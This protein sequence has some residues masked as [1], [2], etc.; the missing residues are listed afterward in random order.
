MHVAAFWLIYNNQVFLG[1]LVLGIV[2]GRCG[3]LMHEGGHYSLTGYIPIDRALQVVLYGVGC[4]MSGSWWRNQHN[5]H[6]S[7]PQKIGHDVDLNTLP[8]VAFTEKVVKK[9]GMSMKWWIRLQAFMFP[10][11]TT[12]LVALGWQFYLHPRHVIRTKNWA[13]LAAMITRYTLWTVLVTSKFGLAQS[14]GMYLLQ[15]WLAANYIFINFAV[16]HTHLDVVPKDDTKV[17][18]RFLYNESSLVTIPFI[19]VIG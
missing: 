16:S 12:S 13:E 1:L 14:V 17:R 15:N 5:K 3:W 9:I 2:C 7:M 10:V 4:G 18:I 6:H 8:L 11:L 19:Y